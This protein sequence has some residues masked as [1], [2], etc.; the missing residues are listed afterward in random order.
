MFQPTSINQ[1]SV[2]TALLDVI[3]VASKEPVSEADYHNVVKCMR[4]FDMMREGGEILSGVEES[5]LLARGWGRYNPF[6]RP[7][8][9]IR[10]GMAFCGIDNPRVA[11]SIRTFQ[12][13]LCNYQ[14]RDP[15]PL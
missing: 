8:E 5:M 6:V 3:Q 1:H 2:F 14:S 11:D 4:E 10:F 7:L 9:R 13:F 15:E 12:S